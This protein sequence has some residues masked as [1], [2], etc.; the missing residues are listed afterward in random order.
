MMVAKKEIFD[1]YCSWLFDI[2]FEVE[3]RTDISNYTTAEARIYGYISERLVDVWVSHNNIKCIE[4]QSINTEN[5]SVL[6]YTLYRLSRKLKIYKAIKN[7]MF[8][9]N[10][11]E[12]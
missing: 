10:K 9:I 6:K 5:K 7:V 4:Y 1:E 12:V 8:N 11:K 2:L 3:K